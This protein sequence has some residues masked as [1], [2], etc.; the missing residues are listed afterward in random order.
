M[1]MVL[2]SINYMVIWLHNQI[3]LF[4]V[5]CLKEIA[6]LGKTVVWEY[7]CRLRTDWHGSLGWSDLGGVLSRAGE[8]QTPCMHAG[9]RPLGDP[10]QCLNYVQQKTNLRCFIQWER[11]ALW[12]SLFAKHSL[13]SPHSRAFSI[14]VVWSLTAFRFFAT[15]G[16]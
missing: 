4:L 13:Y 2:E 10:D 5:G 14:F 8:W 11:K 16:L 1:Q 6:W 7:W 9:S 3:V 12:S 15:H